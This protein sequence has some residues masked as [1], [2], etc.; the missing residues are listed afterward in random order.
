MDNQLTCQEILR[1]ILE[2]PNLVVN[3]VIVQSSE[4]NMA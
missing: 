4:R 2:D 1:T 3:D